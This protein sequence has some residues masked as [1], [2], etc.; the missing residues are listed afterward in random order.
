[1][2]ILSIILVL[3]IVGC[4]SSPL[5]PRT[6][7]PP[8][9]KLSEIID[10]VYGIKNAS[11]H[12]LAWK[13]QEDER[14]LYVESLIAVIEIDK[15]RYLLAHLFRHPR[16]RNSRWRES[17]ITDVAYVG[18][19]SFS[20]PPTQMELLSFLEDTWWSFTEEPGWKILD[21]GLDAEKWK[22]LTGQ[23]LP[24][25][26]LKQI[27]N[28]TPPVPADEATNINVDGTIFDIIDGLQNPKF[29]TKSYI[30]KIFS[31]E[32]VKDEIYSNEYF[33]LYNGG[34]TRHFKNI[35]L[36]ERIAGGGESA[37]LLV[38][39]LSEPLTTNEVKAKYGW[40]HKYGTPVPEA[41]PDAFHY[42]TY[43]Y[44]QRRLSFGFDYKNRIVYRIVI[45]VYRSKE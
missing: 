12:I 1:V 45:E 20:H 21:V 10:E 29:F 22:N 34:P 6:G 24:Q 37:G 35:E 15:T 25:E 11:G 9:W 14:P 38:M 40:N 41:P 3:V 23:E 32:L 7:P 28:D 27:A 30:E 43:Q 39:D 13:T 4:D 31:I 17:V 26:F 42:Y 19:R 18:S 5:T 2:L 8:D 44:N 36:R 16:E 33:N